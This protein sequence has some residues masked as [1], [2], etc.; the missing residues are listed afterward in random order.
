MPERKAR[1]RITEVAAR[2]DVSSA[3]VSRVL[4]GVATV[5]PAHRQR[6][7]KAA[8]E[9][10]YRPNRIASNLRRQQ[11]DMIG[12]V[13]S[14]IENPHFAQ[15][16]RAVE[17]AAYQRGFRVL[18]CNTDENAQKQHDYLAVMAAE[19]VVGVI[20]APSEPSGAEIGV[21]L[22]LGIPVVAF[23]RPVTDPRADAVLV[24]NA[25]AARRATEHLLSG[26]H[27]RIGFIGPALIATGAERQAGYEEAMGAAGL[28]TIAA[29]G[30]FRVETARVAA[31]RLVTEESPTA[32]IAATNFLT[33]GVLQ[34][35][36]ALRLRIPDEMAVVAFDETVWSD[37][38]D[39]PLTT[40][41]Q[42]VRQMATSAVT[43][44]LERVGG[45]HRDPRQLVFD[46]HF[47][48]RRSCG[49][50]GAELVRSTRRREEVPL[51]DQ[52]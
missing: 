20:V 35:L 16:V 18:L 43:L 3:T 42:P 24:D 12:V 28:P 10:G 8:E 50:N 25:G 23:D 49:V 26:G 27:E 7:L 14:D 39:P 2:A 21:V 9:L 51:N 17:D 45:A 38:V 34:A 40:V 30:G 32:L 11:A 29:D 41:E 33:I 5:R 4:N 48:I 47:R 44:L 31:E 13:V 15:M 19:R 46:S 1:V 37:L 52:P 36:R 22:D 6:V